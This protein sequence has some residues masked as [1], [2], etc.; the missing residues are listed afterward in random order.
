MRLRR[1]HFPLLVAG[2]S[3][4]CNQA[5][6]AVRVRNGCG[7]TPSWSLPLRRTMPASSLQRGHS[8]WKPSSRSGN[9]VGPKTSPRCW[10]R[11]PE[12]MPSWARLDSAL[13]YL[14]R[15]IEVRRSLADRAAIRGLT[16]QIAGLH[17]RMGD[18]RRAMDIYIENAPAGPAVS[19]TRTA[20]GKSS[21]RCS[22]RTGLWMTLTASGL[23][24][25]I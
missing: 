13:A 22:R 8:C 19:R 11:S 14:N 24:L 12:A 23:R 15:S 20:F 4:G 18:D 9:T 17:R 2:A 1:F 25:R 3:G 16:L 6:R 5:A 7:Q 21:G 10:K